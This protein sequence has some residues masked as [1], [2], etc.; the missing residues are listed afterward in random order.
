MGG[1]RKTVG[2]AID[3]QVGIEMCVRLGDLVQPGQLLIRVFAHPPDHP[4]IEHYLE[5][6]VQLGD[7]PP[8]RSPL[9]LE[10]CIG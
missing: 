8:E 7:S 10:R 9:I 3:H 2:D 1:G 4:R 5:D 6:A